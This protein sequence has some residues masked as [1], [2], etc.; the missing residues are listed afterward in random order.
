MVIPRDA[1]VFS[2]TLPTPEIW[3]S[4]SE[5]GQSEGTEGGGQ[6]EGDRVRGKRE[7]KEG[8][9]RVRGKSEGEE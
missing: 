9:G 6:S 3:L 1:K 2:V 5:G 8:G 4:M 7:G